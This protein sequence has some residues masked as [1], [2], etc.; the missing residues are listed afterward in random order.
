MFGCPKSFTV[1]LTDGQ[2]STEVAWKEPLFKD[3]VEISHLW[4]SLVSEAVIFSF[5][6]LFS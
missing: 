3:N 6:C 2:V 4:K 1:L 5:F